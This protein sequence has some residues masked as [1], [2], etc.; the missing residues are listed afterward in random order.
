MRTSPCCRWGAPSHLS[1]ERPHRTTGAVFHRWRSSR[2]TSWCLQ[3]RNALRM[4]VYQKLLKTG[5]GISKGGVVTIMST[6][7][8]RITHLAWT[9]HTLW[10]APACVILSIAMAASIL[11]VAVV[12]AVVLAVLLAPLNWLATSKFEKISD[13]LMKWSSKRMQRVTEVR[14]GA[15]TYTGSRRGN[16]SGADTDVARY[17]RAALRRCKASR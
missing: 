5:T 14:S 12:P 7:I 1:R 11:G 2:G 15:H 17:D 13:G 16:T 10:N 9:F 8:G 3:V 6:D 4:A